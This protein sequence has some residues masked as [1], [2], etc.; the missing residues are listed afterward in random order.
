MGIF[1]KLKAEFIDIIEW[2][3][4]SSDTILYRFERYHNE[5]KNNAKLIVRESQVAVFVSEGQVA[6]VF[7]PGTYTLST[8]NLPILSTLKG[9]KYGFNSPFKAEVYFANTKNFTDRKWGT[10]NPIILRD[11]EYGAVRVRAFGTYTLRLKDPVKVIKEVSGTSGHFT[12]DDITDQLRNIIITRFTD[13]LAE[14]KIPIIDLPTQY[15]ELSKLTKEKIAPEYEEY[16]FELTKLLIENVS[17]PESVE[18]DIDRRS[19]MAFI[20][21][22]NNLQKFESANAMRAAAQNPGGG[23][24]SGMGLGMGFAMANQMVGS[25][26]GQQAAPTQQQYAAP[27]PMAGPPPIPQAVAFFAVV[28]GQQTGPFNDAALRQMVQQQQFSPETLVWKQGMPAW[29]KAGQVAELGAIFASAG[30]P[31][32]PPVPPM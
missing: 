18:A 10:K 2:T 32:V 21:D 19:S 11:P 1:N 17:L 20:G 4:S 23:A 30:P 29:T 16:G 31:P 26:G 12:T 28:N 27:P 14:A 5:I 22:L 9:W 24:A 25:F 7:D 8:Q 15:D 3:D 6:D 13:A